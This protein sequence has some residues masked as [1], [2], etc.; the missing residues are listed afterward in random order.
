[1][2]WLILQR[3]SN[4][5]L[6]C[7][8]LQLKDLVKETEVALDYRMDVVLTEACQ[9]VISSSCNSFQEGDPMWV[10]DVRC[11]CCWCVFGATARLVELTHALQKIAGYR[12][13][14]KSFPPSLPL[15]NPNK[16]PFNA[17]KFAT[18]V[19][20]GY[21]RC[22][23]SSMVVVSRRVLSCLMEQLHTKRMTKTCEKR[24]VELQYFI[25]RDFK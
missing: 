19:S 11:C 12:F 23:C 18:G 7:N 10:G 13:L 8:F 3:V 20:T 5:Y 24:L 15:Y 25:S 9:S 16:K 4:I 2:G 14:L 17:S 6:F 21:F 22:G 1:V